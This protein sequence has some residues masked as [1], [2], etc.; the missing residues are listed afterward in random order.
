MTIISDE[1]ELHNVVAHSGLV[2]MAQ[3]SSHLFIEFRHSSECLVW[4]FSRFRLAEFNEGSKEGLITPDYGFELNI[5]EGL[6][7]LLFVSFRVPIFSC[8]MCLFEFL[9]EWLVDTGFLAEQPCFGFLPFRRSI[10]PNG[11]ITVT[12]TVTD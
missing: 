1:K 7:E 6:C 4:Q 2:G 12:S 10:G 11:E 5:Y 9:N 3:F 8:E